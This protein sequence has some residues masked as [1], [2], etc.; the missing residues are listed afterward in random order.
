MPQRAQIVKAYAGYYDLMWQNQTITCRARGN[1]SVKKGARY[2][3]T[4]I[5]TG[6]WVEFSI[7]QDNQGVIE[8]IEPRKNFLDDVRV[9]NIDQVLL[10]LAI[11]NPDLSLRLLNEY[12][13]LMR[14][15]PD[16][17]LLIGFNKIDLL[18]EQEIDLEQLQKDLKKINIPSLLLSAKTK[19]NLEDLKP[20]LTNRVTVVSGPSGSGKSTLIN[21]FFPDR[22]QDTQEVSE[23]IGRGKQTTRFSQ[24]LISPEGI[25]LVDTPG[26]SSVDLK[27]TKENWLQFFPEL[28]ELPGSCQFR[29]CLH[30]KEPRCKVKQAVEN[31]NLPRWRYDYYVETYETLKEF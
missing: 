16:L 29:D 5:Y 1:L 20:F 27:I 6:D 2:Q 8:S 15:V 23:K 24:L 25:T 9:A 28:S 7:T 3:K 11:K 14:S 19:Q 10:L 30:L 31:L 12:L 4:E 26:F 13:V 18:A 21:D 17:P 22:L